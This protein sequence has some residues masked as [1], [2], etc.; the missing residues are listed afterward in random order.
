MKSLLP[1]YQG[2]APMPV[3]IAGKALPEAEQKAIFSDYAAIN[4]AAGVT[5]WASAG[6]ASC[7]HD[8]EVDACVTLPPLD[9]E[10]ERGSYPLVMDQE[11]RGDST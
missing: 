8:G 4:K 1:I 5:A 7:G 3:P 11:R 9:R 2:T 6:V 10:H